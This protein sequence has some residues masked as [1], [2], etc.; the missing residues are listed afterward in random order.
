MKYQVFDPS[1]QSPA[2]GGS[3][4]E[5]L[6]SPEFLCCGVYGVDRV[7]RVRPVLDLAPQAPIASGQ[8]CFG[9]DDPHTMVLD[10]RNAI[11]C[12]R[13]P[14]VWPVGPKA[15]HADGRTQSQGRSQ[16]KGCFL[17]RGARAP[18]AAATRA[19]ILN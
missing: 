18:E 14:E 9:S 12:D 6:R 17:L 15:D 4:R 11:S 19:E 8:D 7:I 10:G 2:P 5:L 13:P 16:R 1:A 3:T